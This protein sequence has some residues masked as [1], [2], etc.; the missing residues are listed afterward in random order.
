MVTTP[1]GTAEGA[2]AF[3]DYLSEKGIVPANTARARRAA[4]KAVLSIDE[5]WEAMDVR[6]LDLDEQFKR[7]ANLKG[8]N[9]TQRSLGEYKI[10]FVNAIEWYKQ[11]LADPITFKVTLTTRRR[12]IKNAAL[13]KPNGKDV[14]ADEPA[15]STDKAPGPIETPVVPVETVVPNQPNQGLIT[16]PFPLRNGAL[17]R[18]QLPLHISS[19]DA[20]RLYAF[21]KTLVIEKEDKRG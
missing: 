2:I 10:R 4:L 7:F 19:D 18:I 6:S 8:T 13:Q 16:Y 21:L 3:L 14:P 20:E 5:G 17:A 9:Y 1:N 15:S 12:P 11:Y